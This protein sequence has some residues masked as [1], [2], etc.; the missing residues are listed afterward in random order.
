MN[1]FDFDPTANAKLETLENPEQKR[2]YQVEFTCPEWTALCPH[3]GFPDFGTIHIKYE[4]KQ[5]CVE[6]KSLKLYINS[7]RNRLI[8]HE[9][10]V[11][12]ILTDLVAACRPWKM[13]V[14]GDFNVRGNIK[15]IIR[16]EYRDPE[17]SAS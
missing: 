15:T 16:A 1:E 5:H 8:Y 12:Q 6:L 17:Y 7:Y 13:E 9:G 4:P 3:S 2:R 11:N 10:A 14:M